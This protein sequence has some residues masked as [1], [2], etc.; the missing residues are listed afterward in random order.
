[1]VR[2]SGVLV[3]GLAA[4]LSS[5]GEAGDPLAIPPADGAADPTSAADWDARLFDKKGKPVRAAYVR[6]AASM[7]PRDLDHRLGPDWGFYHPPAKK[8]VKEAKEA[9]EAKEKP[10]KKP[11]KNARPAVDP[12]TIDGFPLDGP[13]HADG[14]YIWKQADKNA[15]DWTGHGGQ[16]V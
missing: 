1:M 12:G 8:P 10:A 5:A 13:R 15:T 9:K 2:L 3:R 11:V 16:V 6:Q 4:C 14:R 7:E